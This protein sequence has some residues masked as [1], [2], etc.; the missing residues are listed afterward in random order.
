MQVNLFDFELPEDRIALTPQA[1]AILRCRLSSDRT[2]RAK[3]MS[4]CLD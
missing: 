1:R 2:A 4:L 3:I